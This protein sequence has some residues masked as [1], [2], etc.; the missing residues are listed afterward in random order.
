[1]ARG[2]GLVALAAASTAVVAPRAAR[3]DE[4]PL[5]LEVS[6]A[7]PDEAAVRA[8]LAT[9][10][11]P[12]Q[13]RAAPVSIRD[14]GPSYRVAV[15]EEALTFD[16]PARDCAARAR[17]VAAFAADHLR[18]HPPAL[19]PPMW[20]IEKGL[21]YEHALSMSGDSSSWGAEFRGAFG[22]GLWSIFG[23]AGARGPVTMTFA[24][25]FK[26]ELLRVPLD[27]GAR[28]TSHKWRLRPW[29]GVGPSLTVNGILGENLVNTDREWRVG[30]GGLAMAGATLP[31]LKRIGVMAAINLRWEPRAYRLEVDPEGRV[32]ETP[33]WWLGLS[34]N[35]TLD[36]KPSS[37]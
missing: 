32:G 19:G 30:L 21:V 11:S 36:G 17:H 22:P 13:A 33:K 8:L 18:A 7:C 26:A 37:P 12:D 4:S 29:L 5:V 6:G 24:N 3:A 9:L 10:L 15:R 35:Y 14:N 31:L 27:V 2:L 23:S 20:T 16:D 34:L 1:M 28:I 25:G